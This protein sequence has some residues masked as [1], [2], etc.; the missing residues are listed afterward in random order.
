M[1]E[2]TQIPGYELLRQLG[3]GGMATVYLAHQAS[4]DREVALKL[5]SRHLLADHRFAD[6]FLREARIAAKLHHRNVV[7][8]FDVGTFGE[9][10]YIAMEYLSGGSIMPQENEPIA[11]AQ[12]LRSV[13]EIATALDYAHGKGYIH[14]D[15]KP[16][17]ILLR[18]DGSSVLSDFGIARAVDGTTMMTKTGSVVGTPYFMSPEQ[19]RG[20]EIDGRADLYSL[21]VVLY[22]LLT[23]KVPYSA[24]DSLAIGIMHMTAPLP[25]LPAALKDIQPLLDFMMA[26]ELDQRVKTGAEIAALISKIERIRERGVARLDDVQ[27]NSRRTDPIM[28]T[29]LSTPRIEPENKSRN[30]SR[31]EVRSE[32]SIA[33]APEPARGGRIEPSMTQ[34]MLSGGAYRQE[35]TFD[36]PKPAPKSP[37]K[38]QME[39]KRE[40]ALGAI[41]PAMS[42]AVWQRPAAMPTRSWFWPGFFLIAV[43]LAGV[44]FAQKDWLLARYHEFRAQDNQSDLAKAQALEKSGQL[45]GSAGAL[46]HYQRWLTSNPDDTNARAGIERIAAT[47]LASVENLAASANDSVKQNLQIEITELSQALPNDA[48]FKAALAAVQTALVQDAST[49]LSAAKAAEAQK[50]YLGSDGA[51]AGYLA[52]RKA[53]P[54]SIPGMRGV[55]AIER[56]LG[57]QFKKLQQNNETLAVDALANDWREVHPQSELLIAL[58]RKWNDARADSDERSAQIISL[59]QAGEAALGRGDLVSPAGTSAVDRYRAVLAADPRNIAAASGLQAIAAKLIAQ[60]RIAINER[61][62]SMAE[63]LLQQAQQLNGDAVALKDLSDKLNAAIEAQSGPVSV[64]SEADAGRLAKLYADFDSAIESGD[65]NDSVGRSA[66]DLLKQIE[67]NGRDDPEVAQR[68]SALASA[69]RSRFDDAIDRSDYERA[70]DTLASIRALRFGNASQELRTQLAESLASDIRIRIESADFDSAERRLDLLKTIDSK[71]SELESLRLALLQARG[72]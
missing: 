38:P 67:K 69:L 46:S 1:A 3:K 20:R 61:K 18:D 22:Q 36:A 41:D 59:L 52:L 2:P 43:G 47:T 50:R 53:Q 54:D 68:V 44:G 29:K 23:G 45:F 70:A 11:A 55:E 35:P 6:R 40:V 63:N 16:D 33:S 60:A 57:A 15:V 25:Q 28:Q 39:I 48:R 19:L 72:T 14:R 42:D 8:I 12:A 37:A 65:L 66:F 64:P 32:P 4:V 21:G 13:R 51:L 58:L 7:S 49:L 56:L 30:E 71:H 26:K 24:S 27:E 10:P 62:L 31:N 5:M 34:S 17:N 9:Q